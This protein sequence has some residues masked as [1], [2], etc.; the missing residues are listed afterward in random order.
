MII[1]EDLMSDLGLKFDCGIGSIAWDGIA[2]PIRQV[3]HAEQQSQQLP[4]ESRHSELLKQ[5]LKDQKEALDAT[6]TRKHE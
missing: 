3:S 6:S 4:E 2:R 5:A 1:G